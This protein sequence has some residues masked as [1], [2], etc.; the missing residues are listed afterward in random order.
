MRKNSVPSGFVQLFWFILV[1]V[2]RGSLRG[3][4]LQSPCEI[5][6]SGHNGEILGGKPRKKQNSV[7]AAN[8]LLFSSTKA[9]CT[10]S[11]KGAQSQ[12]F[13]MVTCVFVLVD[14][15]SKRKDDGKKP[16]KIAELCHCQLYPYFSSAQAHCTDQLEGK[17]CRAQSQDFIMVTCVFVL[18]DLCSKRKDDGT[19]YCACASSFMQHELLVCSQYVLTMYIVHNVC[20]SHPFL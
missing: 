16:K 7:I 19:R 3:S 18:V 14:L 6:Y 4:F 9:N 11:Q 1:L 10:G 17:L 8:F 5:S 13:I 12:E 15:C 20:M 2:H